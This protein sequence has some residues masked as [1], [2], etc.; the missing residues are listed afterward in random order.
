M[1]ALEIVRSQWEALGLKAALKPEERTLYH[2]RVTQNGEHMIGTW[3]IE[4]TFPLLSGSSN[5]FRHQ[6]LVGVERHHWAKWHVSGGERGVE[7][8]GG[9]ESACS[10]CRRRCR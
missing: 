10:S 6:H 4:T 5:W 8:P 1:D 7:P 2:Q 9:G 3:G